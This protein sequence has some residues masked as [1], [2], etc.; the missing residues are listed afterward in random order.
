MAITVVKTR[1]IGE[2]GE[3]EIVTRWKWEAVRRITD[4]VSG[5]ELASR[6]VDVELTTA[7]LTAYLGDAAAVLT[8]AQTSLSAQLAKLTA[9]LA[10]R[11][12]ERD[13]ALAAAR[14]VAQADT[15]WDA[16]VRPLIDQ[17]TAAAV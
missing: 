17:V 12:A 10:A 4:D 5:E 8:T 13:A 2:I 16:S 9:D 7:E 1:L 3:G 15:L 14:A 6:P 11:T